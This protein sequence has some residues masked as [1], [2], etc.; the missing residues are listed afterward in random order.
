MHTFF[1]YFSVLLLVVSG[2]AALLFLLMIFT[3]AASMGAPGLAGAITV[4][5]T[6][7]ILCLLTDIADT[8]EQML[9]QPEEGPTS[10]N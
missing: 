3:G 10:N 2:L 8:L 1:R 9:P 6:A 4:F 5:I 7:A